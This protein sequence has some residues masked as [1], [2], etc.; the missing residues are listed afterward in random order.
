[1]VDPFAFAVV[2]P[3]AVE[4]VVVGTIVA[5]AAAVGAV[6]VHRAE[7]PFSAVQI[8]L[9]VLLLLSYSNLSYWAGIPAHLFVP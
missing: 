7:S 4:L 1:M 2:W 8:W 5:P 9:H 6:L 3:L